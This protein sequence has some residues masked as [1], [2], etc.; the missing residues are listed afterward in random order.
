[1]RDRLNPM[2][3][4][5]LRRLM[6]DRSIRARLEQGRNER[7]A[8]ASRFGLAIASVMV[9]RSTSDWGWLDQDRSTHR[10]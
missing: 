2:D 6:S 8:D 10:P 7:R 5:M 9:N 4:D 3:A 1:M